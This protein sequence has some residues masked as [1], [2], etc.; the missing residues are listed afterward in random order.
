MK[1][2]FTKGVNG[3]GQIKVIEG[4]LA[5]DD[6]LKTYR[7]HLLEKI[8]EELGTESSYCL[9]SKYSVQKLHETYNKDLVAFSPNSNSDVWMKDASEIFEDR[10]IAED[11]CKNFAEK[12]TI[13][14]RD[15]ML[16]DIQ[17]M[18]SEHMFKYCITSR[19][20]T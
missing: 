13:N 2:I 12:M 11:Y 15:M 10:Q 8:S 20:E 16:S 5:T 17:P 1:T 6:Q 9:K 3:W 19:E 14:L 7:K 18:S 4:K